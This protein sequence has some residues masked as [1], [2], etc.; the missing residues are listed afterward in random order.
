VHEE[1]HC[2]SCRLS[3]ATAAELPFAGVPFVPIL[4]MPPVVAQP[5]RTPLSPELLAMSPRAPP[6]PPSA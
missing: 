2:L 4:A 3:A 6:P 5:V 1:D